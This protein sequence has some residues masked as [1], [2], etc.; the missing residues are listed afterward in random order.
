MIAQAHSFPKEFLSTLGI[1]KPQR[2]CGFLSHSHADT[3]D[4]INYSDS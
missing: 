2:K 3:S 1:G 4:A